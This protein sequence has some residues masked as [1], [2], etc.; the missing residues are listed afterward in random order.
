MDEEKKQKLVARIKFLFEGKFPEVPKSD[1]EVL[2]EGFS[3]AHEA[4][5]MEINA[6]AAI[7][8]N[9]KKHRYTMRDLVCDRLSIGADITAAERAWLI[10]VIS[11]LG[12]MP[13]ESKGRA[14][15]SVD[16]FELTVQLIGFMHRDSNEYPNSAVDDSLKRAAEDIC[17]KHSHSYSTLKTLYYSDAY[18]KLNKYVLL[19]GL[20]D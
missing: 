12:D 5:A 2:G 20:L 14:T 18:K 1:I 9:D 19:R 7:H 11:K 13:H 3:E 10:Y 17:S 6:H 16:K 4:L 8:L 15:R